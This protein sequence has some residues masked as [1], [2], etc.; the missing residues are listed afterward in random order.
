MREFGENHSSTSS[1]TPLAKAHKNNCQYEGTTL[2]PTHNAKKWNHCQE[3]IWK[4]KKQLQIGLLHQKATEKGMCNWS[5]SCYIQVRKLVLVLKKKREKHSVRRKKCMH[6][7]KYIRTLCYDA[8]DII[9][10]EWYIVHPT[11]CNDN[12]SGSSARQLTQQHLQRS[13]ANRIFDMQTIYATKK[14]CQKLADS[15]MRSMQESKKLKVFC[16]ILRI[17]S[18]WNAQSTYLSPVTEAAISNFKKLIWV[19]AYNTFT[20]M[21]TPS[22]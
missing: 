1:I 13:V 3:T 19:Q 7:Y 4:K 21:H 5:R 8:T 6:I 18:S 2:V 9:E 16:K 11:V 15:C 20:H 10:S 17:R 12:V 22:H 14:A